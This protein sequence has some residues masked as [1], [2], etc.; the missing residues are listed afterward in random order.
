MSI[1][2][3]ERWYFYQSLSVILLSELTDRGGSYV[4]MTAD[5]K[6]SQQ[7]EFS[8]KQLLLTDITDVLNVSGARCDLEI[9]LQMLPNARLH[10]DAL[11]WCKSVDVTDRPGNH[12]MVFCRWRPAAPDQ[13][14]TTATILSGKFTRLNI[15]RRGGSSP[16]WQKGFSESEQ[17]RRG[18][19]SRH[20]AT[21]ATELLFTERTVLVILI[22]RKT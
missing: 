1:D 11:P 9:V 13:S 18:A 10:S 16:F 5:G 4:I 2:I 19:Q 15:V 17:N 3:I 20:P 6:T 8:I 14:F 21:I 22:T 12:M 7:R